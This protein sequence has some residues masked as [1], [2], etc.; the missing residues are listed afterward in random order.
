MD[1]ILP[2]LIITAFILILTNNKGRKPVEQCK[3]HKWIDVDQPGMDGVTYI[4]CSICNKTP[5][6]V[7]DD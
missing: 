2:I 3:L 6:E 1:V 5:T 4:Q 7:I